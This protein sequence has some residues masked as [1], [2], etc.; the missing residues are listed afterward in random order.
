MSKRYAL[1]AEA[2]HDRVEIFEYLVEAADLDTALRVDQ[3][4]EQVFDLLVS[5]PSIGHTRDDLFLPESVRV[6]SVYSWMIIYR[7]DI[8]PLRILR[9]WHGAQEK[10]EIPD[11]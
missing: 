7:P 11:F 5:R 10:P 1:S 9:I 8:S 6:W 3:K 2:A 4:I